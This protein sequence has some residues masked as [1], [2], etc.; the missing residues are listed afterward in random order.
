MGK[1]KE[2][3]ILAGGLGTRIRSSIK[4]G[5]PKVLAPINGR[6]FIDY[7]LD[8]LER[9]GV[10]KVILALGYGANEVV[11]YIESCSREIIIDHVVEEHALGTGGAVV[12][13]LK[14]L[15]DLQA[16]VINGDSF[17]HV[18]LVGMA[19][20]HEKKHAELTLAVTRV[21]DVSR[22]GKVVTD[23]DMRVI[24][25]E[26]KLCS[27]GQGYIN[28]GIYLIDRKVFEQFPANRNISLEM[29]ILKTNV[30]KRMYG[31][32]C[33]LPFIDIGTEQSFNEAQVFSFS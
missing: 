28:A 21:D 2:A 29:E 18:D 8:Y 15:D 17:I 14:K 19:S 6:P 4:E 10:E 25:F 13:C 3:I 9:Q 32:L 22:F 27:K 33:D 1:V 5:L 7:Q 20:Q 12:N 31:F 30:Q 23:D 26:E 16:Y 11:S 24:D